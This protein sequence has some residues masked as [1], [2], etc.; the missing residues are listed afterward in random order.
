MKRLVAIWVGVFVTLLWSSSYILN[1]VVFE[2]GITPITLAGLRYSIAVLVMYAISIVLRS[3]QKKVNKQ[4]EINTITS[5]LTMKH[6]FLLGITGYV[7]AQGLQYAGQFFIS[8]TQTRNFESGSLIGIGFVLLSSVG[9]TINLR[10]TRYYISN[11]LAQVKELVLR[12][13]FIGAVFMVFLDY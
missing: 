10:A 11:N 8:P 9:Y 2:E 13:M 3:R 1:K 7:M 5:K 4:K 12:P 6:Y